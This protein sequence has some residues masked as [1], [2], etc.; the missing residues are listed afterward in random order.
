MTMCMSIFVIAI[1]TSIISSN[2]ADEWKIQQQV[3]TREKIVLL[4]KAEAS[5]ID[6]LEKQQLKMNV[7]HEQ[8]VVYLRLIQEIQ[9]KIDSVNPPKY[10]KLCQEQEI[11]NKLAL[12]KIEEVEREIQTLNLKTKTVQSKFSFSKS[13][14]K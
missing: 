13:T 3:E 12:M 5:N 7:L 8:N 4:Q 2:V 6:P 10:L 1:P 11:K 9:E 14:T